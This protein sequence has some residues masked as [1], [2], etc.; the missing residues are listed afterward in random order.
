MKLINKILHYTVNTNEEVGMWTEKIICDIIDIPFKSS[1]QY[2]N[3]NNYPYKLKKDLSCSISKLLTTLQ[4]KEHI[5]NKNECNDYIC[6]NNDLVS[7]KTNTSGFKVCPA[8][9][10]QTTLQQLN[11]HF[12][13]EFTK[14]EFKSYIMKNTNDILIE[15]LKY[16]FI[17]DHLLSI[18]FDKGKVYYFKSELSC[19]KLNVSNFTFTNSLE[20]WNESNTVKVKVNDKLMSLAEFQIHTNR[21]CIKCRFNFDTIIE[22]IRLDLISG[23]VLQEFDLKYKYNI[24]VVKN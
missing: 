7:L 13:I 11:K 1:R 24:K 21:N 10:G 17:C 4:I 16:S 20:N 23:I 18:K 5:G 6:V 8:K 3:Q 15:Y 22:M 2:I 9:I 12:R 19:I 14:Q